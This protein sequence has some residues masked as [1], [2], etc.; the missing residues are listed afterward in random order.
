MET[1][2]STYTLLL[3][4][5]DQQRL[6]YHRICKT[7]TWLRLLAFSG[8][9]I[10]FYFA[11][12]A[13]SPIPGFIMASAFIFL[14]AVFVYFNSR[15]QHKK[16]YFE[17]LVQRCELEL[18]ALKFDFL[19]LDEGAE[20]VDHSHDYA[21]DLDVFGH[22]SIFQY[23]NRTVTHGGRIQLARW[24]KKPELNTTEILA[25]QESVRELGNHTF[26]RLSFMATGLLKGRSGSTENLKF[27][28][29][30]K[31][32]FSKH[33]LFSKGI[34]LWQAV[35]TGILFSVLMGWMNY[36][37][38]VLLGLI[39]L[40]IV[41]YYLKKING[42]SL[43]FG[44]TYSFLSSYSDLMEKLGEIDLETSWIRSRKQS[45]LG[46]NSNAPAEIR[47]LGRILQKF[48]SR[49]NLLIGFFRNALF[50][51]DLLLVIRMEIWKSRN[52]AN[53]LKW[54]DILGEIDAL[55]SLSTYAYNN[56]GYTYPVPESGEFSLYAE[57]LGHP[58]IPP[59][60]RVCNLFNLQGWH[61]I[62]VLT[63]ANMAGKSTFLR[64]IGLNQ[65]LAM[66]GAPVCAD[67]Y[68]FLPIQLITS[69]RTNDSLI[70]HE[71]YFYAELKKLKNIID[72][73]ER[74]EKVFFLLDEVL[75]G[76]NSN[77]KLNG[78]IILVRKLLNLSASGIIATHDIALGE[79]E[80]EFPGQVLNFCFEADI[81]DGQLSFDYKMKNGAAKSMTALFL[82]KQM[83]IVS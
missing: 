13:D 30:Q 5:F 41:G 31:N 46:R 32:I 82:M 38:L 25:R 72:V 74:G 23:L 81:T 35:M 22:G 27:W 62:I 43:V 4:Q 52:S 1:P 55:I 51:T 75:K 73:L 66:T 76:T 28:L 33:K 60:E 77:D 7:F 48:D 53:I 34:R 44:K 63:G 10:N 29:E 56:P 40:G 70:K 69:I 36:A 59:Q 8:I 80:A 6:K 79:L 14:L 19:G 37:I 61:S 39:N 18:K 24:L 3:D 45:L 83:G 78:S 2:E 15:F 49:N 65:V 17:T 12:T 20:F 57:N 54:F 64:T 71:S 26:W 11:L 50:L 21:S 67:A 9:L 58:L 47:T 42:I 68:G 16:S